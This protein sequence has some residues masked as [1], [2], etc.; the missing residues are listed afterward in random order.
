[1]EEGAL[2]LNCWVL[3]VTRFERYLGRR[4]GESCMRAALPMPTSLCVRG[5]CP[6]PPGAADKAIQQ[7]GRSHRSNQVSAPI[8]KLC[9]TNVGGERRFAAAAA[10]AAA[11]AADVAAAAGGACLTGTTSSSKRVRSCRRVCAWA[12]WWK[13]WRPRMC[14]AGTPRLGVRRGRRRAGAE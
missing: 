11:T 6:F 12:C 7:L 9:F 14:R 13:G 3:Q 4:V 2:R 8:Y 5:R 10:A 1:M